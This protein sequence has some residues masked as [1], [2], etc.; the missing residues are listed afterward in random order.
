M[1]NKVG[2][3]NIVPRYRTITEL[4]KESGIPAWVI[5]QM[6]KDGDVE[7]CRPGKTYYVNGESFYSYLKRMN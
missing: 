4:A 3:E 7:Y 1:C 2:T 5:R 6:I